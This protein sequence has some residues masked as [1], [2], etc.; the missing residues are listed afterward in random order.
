MVESIYCNL[1]D[2]RHVIKI[3]ETQW[4]SLGGG[5]AEAA[6]Q[7]PRIERSFPSVF[8]VQTL[9]SVFAISYFLTY[10][11]NLVLCVFSNI[12][13]VSCFLFPVSC[14]QLGLVCFPCPCLCPV[15]FV[16]VFAFHLCMLVF[17]VLSLWLLLPVFILPSVFFMFG[18]LVLIVILTFWF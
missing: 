15:N 16:F 18:P 5:A 14:L 13:L 3:G 12:G 4:R 2:E 11:P 10:F 7:N 6:S 8:I 17:S 9:H 1:L